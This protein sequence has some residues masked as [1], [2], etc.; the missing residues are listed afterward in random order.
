MGWSCARSTSCWIEPAG[1]PRHLRGVLYTFPSD[2]WAEA[3]RAYQRPYETPLAARA[4]EAVLPDPAR[5]A[6]T[7]F[8]GW[9]WCRAADGS[10][11]WVPESWLVQQG[12]QWRLRRDFSALELTLLPGQRVRLQFSESGFV[13]VR[14]EAGEEGWVPDAVLRLVQP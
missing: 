8:L 10:E 5:S 7:D 6:T 14:T 13:H 1:T 12:G 2:S 4:G 9:L 11:G 3:I